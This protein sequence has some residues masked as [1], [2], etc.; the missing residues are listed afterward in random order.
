MGKEGAKGWVNPC[1]RE[2]RAQAARRQAPVKTP[3]CWET[4]TSLTWDLAN[5]SWGTDT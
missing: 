3:Y 5:L 1:E 2:G 4:A